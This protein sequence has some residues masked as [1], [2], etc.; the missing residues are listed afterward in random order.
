MP[1]LH[2]IIRT[3]VP[4]AFK[5]GGKKYGLA[6]GGLNHEME[7]AI[8]CVRQCMLNLLAQQ[9]GLKDAPDPL[10]LLIHGT[11]ENIMLC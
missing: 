11:S 7:H 2:P 8:A 6:G 3:L 10:D 1:F 5:I 9:G 4:C